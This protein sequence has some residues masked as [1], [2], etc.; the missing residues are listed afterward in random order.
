LDGEVERK[1]NDI[2]PEKRKDSRIGLEIK[3]RLTSL[4]TNSNIYGWVQDL[5]NGGFKLKTEIPLELKDTLQ[6][7]DKVKF[8][9]Y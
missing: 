7:G 5:S 6:E 3:I 4:K 1:M 8:Q 2:P 9:T